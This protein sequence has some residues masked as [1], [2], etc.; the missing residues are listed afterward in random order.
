MNKKLITA[1]MSL[2]LFSTLAA[3][4][5]EIGAPEERLL[6]RDE[7]IEKNILQSFDDDGNEVLV[8]DYD[9]ALADWDEVD[10]LY[11][12]YWE[13]FQDGEVT[14]EAVINKLSGWKNDVW[15][16]SKRTLTYCVSN[17]FGSR[18]SR[19]VNAMNTAAGAW[20]G[21][22]AK[23]N[24]VY[25]PAQDGNC[26]NSNNSVVFNVVPYSQQGGAIAV[27]FFP[28]Q[29]RAN[30]QVRINTALAFTSSFSLAGILRHEL[31][32][33]LGLRHESAQAQAIAT[34]GWHCYE[35]AWLQ[36]LTAYDENSVMMTPACTG[37]AFK[38]KSLSLS[39]LD[40]AAIKNLYR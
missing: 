6:T 21:T 28:A 32:H 11:Q 14:S 27:A 39:A 37:S 20:E 9:L 18:K 17:A 24:Y 25:V 15:P 7:F 31:G 10:F 22:G 40:R 34:Y 29:S 26:T 33:T 16:A 19:V 2:A 4:A 36:A 30:R 13:E 1:T 35:N 38:N 12:A 3:C 5:G 23:I 8:Y